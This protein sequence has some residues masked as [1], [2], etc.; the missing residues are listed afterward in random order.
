MHWAKQP[1]A[2]ESG[3]HGQRPKGGHHGPCEDVPRQPRPHWRESIRHWEKNG[4]S[5][6]PFGKKAKGE[7]VPMYREIAD[8]VATATVPDAAVHTLEVEGWTVR[9]LAQP[10]A[11]KSK[12]KA[13]AVNA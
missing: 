6:I 11:A 9:P 3:N 2:P 12:A 1:S 5:T 10:K 4:W 8:G 7:A 13:E